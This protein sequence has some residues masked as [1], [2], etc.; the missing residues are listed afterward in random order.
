MNINDKEEKMLK[1]ILHYIWHK[2]E[3]IV[4]FTVGLW[5]LMLVPIK[6]DQMLTALFNLGFVSLL[7][8]LMLGNMI[9]IGRGSIFTMFCI[10]IISILTLQIIGM[11]V[12]NQYIAHH[13]TEAIPY[14]IR[15][16]YF[17]PPVLAGALYFLAKSRNLKTN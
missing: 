4:V 14:L 2:Q 16:L 6:N 5:G 12:L 1:E 9:K 13:T 10:A 15:L 8:L 17:T 3:V 11:I 7:V